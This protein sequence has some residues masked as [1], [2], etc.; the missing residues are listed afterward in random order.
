MDANY[1]PRFRHQNFMF[2]LLNC[3]LVAGVVEFM[4]LVM[5][6]LA[7]SSHMIACTLLALRTLLFNF[8][9]MNLCFLLLS[10]MF[11]M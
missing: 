3:V 9:G 7:G 8:R 4:E 5:A 6:G 11:V 10:L 1:S 2:L